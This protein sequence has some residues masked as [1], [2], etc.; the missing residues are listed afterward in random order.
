MSEIWLDAETYYNGTKQVALSSLFHR[1]STY[2]IIV[3]DHTVLLVKTHNN[4]WYFPGGGLN[5]GESLH[6]GLKR[7]A[8]E[9]LGVEIEVGELLHADDMVYF[10][11]PNGVAAH[12]VR[13]Y[14]CCTTNA[15]E[16]HY[17]NA[18]ERAEFL[19][20]GWV[21]LDNMNPDDFLPSTLRALTA[22]KQ[23]LIPTN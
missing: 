4:K 16:F 1:V 14:Y 9:E 3:R 20:I 2:A 12:L 23:R 5:L 11:D 15:K 17:E 18:E 21:S 10:H 19:E 7:E 8:R 22:I 6:E 13:L